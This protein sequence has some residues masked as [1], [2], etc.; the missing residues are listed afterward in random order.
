MIVF[1]DS[2]SPVCQNNDFAITNG[3]Q[4]ICKN[5]KRKKFRAKKN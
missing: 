5:S 1:N 3:Q 4:D 2:F